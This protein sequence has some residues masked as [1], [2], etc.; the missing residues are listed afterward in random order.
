MPDLL[1]PTRFVKSISETIIGDK[2]M[3]G[4]TIYSIHITYHRD[5]FDWIDIQNN[6][7]KICHDSI[8]FQICTTDK[9]LKY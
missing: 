5:Y 6:L 9:T 3:A 7:S 1:F 8:L 2:M 4:D